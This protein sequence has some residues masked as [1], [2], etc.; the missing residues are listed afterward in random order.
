MRATAPWIRNLMILFA[1]AGVA[2]GQATRLATTRATT[3]PTSRPLTATRPAPVYRAATQPAKPLKLVP[4]TA[5]DLRALQAEVKDVVARVAPAVVGL[6]VGG[7]QGS[8]VIISEDGF[9]LTA[10]HVSSAPDRDVIVLLPDGKSVHGKTLGI[11]Y[12][13]DSGLIKI[14]VPPPGGGDKW[15]FA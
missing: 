3:R 11:N 14:T 8:G 12:G 7:G 1:L 13:A 2:N 4:E 6:R 15:P 5:D 9:V 10:G